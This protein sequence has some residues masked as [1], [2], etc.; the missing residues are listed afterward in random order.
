MRA[1]LI[2]AAWSEQILREVTEHLMQNRPHFTKESADRLVRAMNTAYPYAQRNPTA[3][4]FSALAH[5]DLPDE[6]DRHVIAAALGAPASAICTHNVGD[7]PPEIVRRLHIDVV[8]PDDLL[9][10]LIEDCQESM[11]WVHHTAVESL[12]AATD[13]STMRALTKAGAPKTAALMRQVLGL[14]ATA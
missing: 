9:C 5:I 1:K 12:S 11:M 14:A 4:D 6:D 2:Q 10:R 13:E 8:T 7:F 3:A